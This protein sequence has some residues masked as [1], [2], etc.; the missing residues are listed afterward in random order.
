M[1]LSLISDDDIKA[2]KSKDDQYGLFIDEEIFPAAFLL[3]KYPKPINI[4]E[5]PFNL[6]DERPEIQKAFLAEKK[7]ISMFFLVDRMTGIL[8]EMTGKEIDLQLISDLHEIAKKQLNSTG[9]YNYAID[10]IYN[11]YPV[12]ES[13]WDK[14]KKYPYVDDMIVDLKKLKK[15][16]IPEVT[17]TRKK[18]SPEITMRAYRKILIFGSIFLYAIII[19]VAYFLFKG[20]PESEIPVIDTGGKPSIAVVYFENK[21]GDES[22]DNWRSALAELII[23]DLSQSQY[24]R[25][26][27]SDRIFSI[28]KKSNLLEA[29]KYSM[30]DLKTIANQGRVDYILKGNYIKVGEI[31]VITSILQKVS[32]GEIISSLRVEGRGLENIFT[33]VDELTKKIK[34]NLNLTKNQIDSDIDK[35]VGKITTS[36]PEAYEYYAEGRKYH[37][38]GEYRKSVQLMEKAVAIDPE[39]AMAYRSIGASYENMGYRS[40]SMKYLRKAK[41]LSDRLSDRER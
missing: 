18:T 22:L 15:D 32:N 17:V 12:L 13:L 39:F 5:L 24:L 1:A 35:E 16:T 6:A 8:K 41:E 33:K 23:T 36:S 19:V 2:F 25:V 14:C 3:W 27:H 37:I 29:K 40:E 30:E 28:F 34:L 11:M 20:K 31:F 7:S 10:Q 26:L 38:A 4:V 21:S 9:D